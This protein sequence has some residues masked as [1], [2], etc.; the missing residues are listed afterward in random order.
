MGKGQI[1]G[2]FRDLTGQGWN[3]VEAAEPVRSEVRFPESANFRKMSMDFRKPSPKINPINLLNDINFIPYKPGSNGAG[4]LLLPAY[5]KKYE[6][7]FTLW[8]GAAGN[9]CFYRGCCSNYLPAF[10]ER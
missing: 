8:S 4:T 6:I 5:Q 9:A 1:S 10:R 7:V 2:N 3:E